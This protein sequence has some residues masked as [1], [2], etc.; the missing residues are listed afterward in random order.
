MELSV[1]LIDSVNEQT[2]D[3]WMLNENLSWCLNDNSYLASQVSEMS[4]RINILKT[5][6]I[7]FDEKTG[8]SKVGK[9]KVSIFKEE[10]EENIKYLNLS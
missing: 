8:T 1:L 5:K 4:V 6:N 10:M 2:T 7:K 3:N 9:S